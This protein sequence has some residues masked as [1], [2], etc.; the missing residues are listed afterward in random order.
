MNNPVKGHRVCFTYR[1][2]YFTYTVQHP[3][4]AIP[5]S[6][7]IPWQHSAPQLYRFTQMSVKPNFSYFSAR[8]PAPGIYM[9]EGYNPGASLD[10]LEN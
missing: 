4:K 9:K 7:A 10:E 6:E 1:H 5:V 8:E 2:R 3:D